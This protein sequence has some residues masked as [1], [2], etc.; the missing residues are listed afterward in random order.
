MELKWQVNAEKGSQEIIPGRNTIRITLKPGEILSQVKASLDIPPSPKMFFNGFQSWTY[1]P[2]FTPE[3]RI[4]GA[5]GLLRPLSKM[6]ALDHFADYHFI[7][8]PHR[9]GILH[10]FSYCYFRENEHYTLIASL[11]ERPGY[12]LFTYNCETGIL[13]IERDCKG[14]SSQ[15]EN[16]T[17]FDLF[18]AQ[19]GEEEVFNGWFDC[20]GIHNDPPKIKGYSSWYNRYQ[21][22]N[23]QNILNDLAGAKKFFTPGDL[24]QIDDG[25]EK[26]VGDW[27]AADKRKFPN[28]LKPIVD[29]IHASGFKAGLWIAPFVCEKKS[30]IY[31]EHPDWL[32]RYKNG[33]WKNG[34]NWGGSYSLDIDNPGVQTYLREVFTRLFDEW[35]FDLV[36]LDFL[37]AAAPH[38]TGDHGKENDGP[39][40]ESRAARMTRA[41]KFL[42][43]CCKEKLILGCG[44]PLMPAFGL[45]D[46]CRIGSD[47]SLDW[48]D[49]FFMHILHRERVST[50]HS[51]SNTIFRRQLDGRAFGIDPDVFFLRDS[52]LSLSEKERIYLASVNALLGSVWLTSDDLNLYDKKKTDMYKQLSK[53][54]GAEDIHADPENMTI[55]F[56]L[57]DAEYSI[58]HLHK[59]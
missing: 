27:E 10:G 2:E 19:G 39:F 37:Y 24:F 9:K 3:H 4:R 30:L 20:M 59:I 15:E 33:F 1:S 54:C 41:L 6:L 49:I 50:H 16:F 42:R 52:N 44:V 28:G 34:P 35:G 47:M 58:R 5:H 18:Y 14:V 8:Y 45:V 53:L 51:V 38:H 25:W 56:R 46:Y 29:K 31:R 26:H 22:I 7:P 32:L 55:R 57:N 11:D 12:T 13:F 36:K 21:R 17:A 23:E 43:E 40:S 48:D